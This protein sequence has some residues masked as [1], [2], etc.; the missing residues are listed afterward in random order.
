MD[1]N[2]AYNL[3][4]VIAGAFQLGSLV[5][6]WQASVPTV[7]TTCVKKWNDDVNVQTQLHCRTQYVK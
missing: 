6:Q 1:Y 3:L 4:Q 7:E 2:K 5:I